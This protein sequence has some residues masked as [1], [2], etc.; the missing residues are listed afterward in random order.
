MPPAL[1]LRLIV[2]R[3]LSNE[4]DIPPMLKDVL[5]SGVFTAGAASP[6]KRKA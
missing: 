4:S 5:K 3:L 2:R 6:V 1:T